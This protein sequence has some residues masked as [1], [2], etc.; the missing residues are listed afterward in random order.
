LVID[1]RRAMLPDEA[2]AQGET[3]FVGF[4]EAVM[5]ML[6]QR[7]NPSV[8]L[9]LAVS[10]LLVLG[11]VLVAWERIRGARGARNAETD[12]TTG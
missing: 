4:H 12:A 9:V 11:V 1:G 3:A 10:I 2:G 7:N 5:V 8:P 6:I